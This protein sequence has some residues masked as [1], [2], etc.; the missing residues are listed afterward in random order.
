[1]CHLHNETV[2]VWSHLIAFLVM[3][4]LLI[5]TM[6]VLSPHGA[7]RLDLDVVLSSRPICD[8]P[9][10]VE[11]SPLCDSIIDINPNPTDSTGSEDPLELLHKIL[12]EHQDEML[13]ELL[14]RVQ[15]HVPN[16]Q[17]LTQTLK[18]KASSIQDSLYA[19]LPEDTSRQFKQLKDD[20]SLTFTEY[21]NQMDEKLLSLKKSLST[22][23][24]PATSGV[25]GDTAAKAQARVSK[26]YAQ[27]KD[28][29]YEMS[30]IFSPDLFHYASPRNLDLIRLTEQV[31]EGFLDQ[32]HFRGGFTLS[33]T[34]VGRPNVKVK[35]KSPV[36]AGM[37][38]GSGT[39]FAQGLEDAMD[40]LSA[41]RSGQHHET[42]LIKAHEHSSTTVDQDGAGKTTSTAIGYMTIEAHTSKSQPGLVQ[43]QLHS[44]LPRYP[45]AIFIITAMMCLLFSSIY[46]LMHAVSFEWAR[47]FQALDYAGIVLLTAGS[48][49]PI[50]YY[51]FYV[52]TKHAHQTQHTREA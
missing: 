47:R 51:G 29:L 6:M 26:E 46:H 1:M 48:T 32:T 20:T 36:A 15:I 37:P 27:L 2:N 9:E 49:H 11:R 14:S 31:F 18:E 8:V 16:L 12:G 3:T 50:I 45:L 24:T 13:I 52:R 30:K 42:E 41:Q 43:L 21:V 35:V 39:I 5:A 25:V 40:D 17:H 28:T 4:G 23:L 34:L 33:P 10:G 38:L 22:F 19:A 7:D 44:Y